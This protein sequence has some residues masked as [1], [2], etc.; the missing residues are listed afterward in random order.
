MQL[1]QI[2]S[3]EWPLRLG[4]GLMYVYS[5]ISLLRQPLD[6]QGFL[7]M[8][9]SDAVV[10]FLPLAT[11]LAIQGA[12]ELVLAAAFL[13]WFLPRGLVRIA[14]GLAALEM[15]GILVLTGID[16]ITFRDVGLLGGA[17]ALFILLGRRP[18][19]GGEGQKSHA[20]IF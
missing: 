18:E 19:S 17:L 2:F 4:L 14:A 16:L 8:W 5:G 1:R 12:G 7:P 3:P 13:A 11:Y 10:R 20:N 15:L 9:F 6:W